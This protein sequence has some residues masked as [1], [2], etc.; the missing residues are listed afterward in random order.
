MH[1]ACEL[2]PPSAGLSLP[3]PPSSAIPS[4]H[5]SLN[6]FQN[7]SATTLSLPTFL[8]NGKAKLK[9]EW[10][11]LPT[12]PH[13]SYP[14][15]TPPALLFEVP[16]PSCSAQQS[17]LGAWAALKVYFQL[18]KIRKKPNQQLSGMQGRFIQGGQRGVWPAGKAW[19]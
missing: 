14:P 11:W 5:L 16:W 17:F 3:P 8:S 13:D 12:K 10:P 4:L 7:L 6:H 18:K 19:R 15:R 9:A 2:T 1:S